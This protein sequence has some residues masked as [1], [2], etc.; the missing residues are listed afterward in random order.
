M[1]RYL[2]PH[3]TRPGS[4]PGALVAD[5]DPPV[6]H[7]LQIW[8]VCFDAETVDEASYDT[9]GHWPDEATG[10]RCDWFHF[11]GDVPA[12]V[13]E[14]LRASFQLHP[15]AVE[16]V[17]KLGQRPKLE[18]FEHNLFVVMVLPVRRDGILH[19]EQ[20]SLFIGSNQVLSFH[21]GGGDLFASVRRRLHEGRGRI[22]HGGTD[23]LLYAL[24]D[25]VV[26]HGFPLLETYAEELEALE[27]QI[28][29]EPR[30]DPVAAIH[31]I[32]RD[33]IGLRKVL[34]HQDAMLVDLIRS[35]HILIDDIDLPY[36]RDAEDHARRINDL[37]D[38][39][40]DTCTS[41]LA[42]HLSLSSARLSDVMKVLTMIATIFLPLSFMAGVYGMNF[43]T[44]SP[45]NMP[46]LGYPYAYPIL[47]AVM[48]AVAGGMLG[49]FRWR[50]WI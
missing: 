27:E 40:R 1:L 19:F 42:T 18:I 20:V 9:V 15:L 37:L 2:L 45:W 41:L 12:P 28:F 13:L 10:G 48:L 47:I 44:S 3:T 43:D 23:Y 36:F 32:K 34:W 39:Y 16:D 30:R 17:H 31:T 7:P 46:E 33:L 29:T 8:H 38:G 49:F 25:V 35:E 21:A 5:A 50:K 22:R 26:D 24:A 11:Q 14:R 6:P 4:R